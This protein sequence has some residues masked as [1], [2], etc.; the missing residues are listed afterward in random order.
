MAQNMCPTWCRTTMTGVTITPRSSHSATVLNGRLYII[1]GYGGEPRKHDV[2][3]NIFSIDMAAQTLEVTEEAPLD[4]AEKRMGHAALPV[5]NNIYTHG[6][7]NGKK[8]LDHGALYDVDSEFI[9]QEKHKGR[10]M[11]EARR[12]HTMT[13][14]GRTLVLF[15]GFG[16]GQQYNDVWTLDV[17]KWKWKEQL[18]ENA[19]CPRRGHSTTRIGKKLFVFGGMYG[20]SKFLD[21][22]WCLDMES[23]TPTW[24][25]LTA[26]G[27]APSCRAWHTACAVGSSSQI[28]FFGGTAGRTNF[29]NDLYVLDTEKLIW[30]RLPTV[31][32]SFIAGDATK[33]ETATHTRG[34]SL[35]GDDESRPR[36]RC[37]HTAVMYGSKMYVFGGIGPTSSDN[38]VVPMND[39]V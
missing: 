7:W 38:K 18:L 11:P 15:G 39:M 8:Y 34:P 2:Q 22:L 5:F 19:P 33:N 16:N 9:L 25:C 27:D 13:L 26:D 21:D 24:T 29:Y 30:F 17:L 31:G 6:G 35:L 12:D 20:Y 36:P 3:S 4:K 23:E 14:C 1:G 10:V 37:S 32:A 28:I